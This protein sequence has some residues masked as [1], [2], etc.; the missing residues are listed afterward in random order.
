MFL[1]GAALTTASPAL[2]A[3]NIPVPAGSY[4]NFKGKDW[5]WA[6]PC[7]PTGCG[8]GLGLDAVDLTYQLAQGWRIAETADFVSGPAPADFR[9]ADGS[10]RCASA[11]FTATKTH[12]D[13]GD[14][15][16]GNIWNRKGIGGS[17]G[18]ET[19]AVRD[20]PAAVPE[21]AAWAFMI[22]GFGLVGGSMR[23]AHRKRKVSVTFGW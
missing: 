11:Y 12:C 22:G 7:A 14:A 1:G 6:S 15:L 5:A 23:S 2:A 19:W 13:Y 9:N 8:T 18:F 3:V 4:I 10:L 17:L 21:P 20:V 16:A